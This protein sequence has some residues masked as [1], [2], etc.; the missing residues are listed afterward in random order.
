MAASDEPVL[1]DEEDPP[2]GVMPYLDEVGVL[3]IPFKSPRRYHWWNGR[4][5]ASETLCELTGK[6]HA[7][8]HRGN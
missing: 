1:Q 2:G 8:S 5:K 7:T 3:V 4:Q 6:P